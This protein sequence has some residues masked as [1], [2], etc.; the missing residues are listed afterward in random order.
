MVWEG[1]LKSLERRVATT[2]DCLSKVVEAVDHVPV[3]II[4]QLVVGLQARVGLHDGVLWSQSVSVRQAT[5]H[6]RQVGR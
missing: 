4:G 6:A 5:T 1:S 3:V 2:H